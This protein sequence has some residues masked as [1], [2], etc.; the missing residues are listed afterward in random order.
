MGGIIIVGHGE[1]PAAL[2]AAAEMILGP[3]TGVRTLNLYQDTNLE[4]FSENLFEII[5]KMEDGNGVLILCDVLGGSPGNAATTMMGKGV[6]VVSGVNLPMLLEVLG[7]R[8]LSCSQ[9]AV[10]AKTAG[11]NGI[12]RVNDLLREE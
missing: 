4:S 9:L 7:K 11:Q 8:N 1:A 3:Q 6:E 2:L 10:L 5:Q 12:A